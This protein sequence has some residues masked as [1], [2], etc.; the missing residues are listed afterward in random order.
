LPVS[1]HVARRSIYRNLSQRKNV[2][3]R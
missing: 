2:R 3:T 1:W